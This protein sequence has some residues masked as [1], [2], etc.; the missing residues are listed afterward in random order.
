TG[1]RLLQ[2][3]VR[4]VG[5]LAALPESVLIAKLGRATGEHLHALANARDQRRVEPDRPVKSIS[6]EE[7]Y[8]RDRHDHAELEIELLRMADA[9]ARRAR[10]GGR[11]GRTVT[12]KVRFGDFRTITRSRTLDRPTDSARQIA[13]V[14]RALLADVD[15]SIGV[16]L[17]GIGIA[18]LRD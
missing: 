16:R 6:H 9:V 1:E 17:L 2:I 11:R 18:G 12:I 14:G 4:T 5:D 13:Q 7:T 3:G 8:A 10:S 15:T